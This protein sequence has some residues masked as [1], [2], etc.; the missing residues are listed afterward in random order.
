MTM[1]ISSKAE[2]TTA[3]A[4]FPA[5]QNPALAKQRTR[6]T[7]QNAENFATSM[8]FLWGSRQFDMKQD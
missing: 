8:G 7:R 3:P 5:H 4:I 2:K 6:L 1:N